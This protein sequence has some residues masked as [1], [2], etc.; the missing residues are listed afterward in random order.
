MAQWTHRALALLASLSVIAQ[1]SFTTAQLP[2]TDASALTATIDT[3]DAPGA[4]TLAL[5][6][7]SASLEMWLPP[8]WAQRL[9][10]P[11]RLAPPPAMLGPSAAESVAQN[12]RLGVNF[13][14][15]PKS[16]VGTTYP[17][18]RNAGASYNRTIFN[19][20]MLKPSPTAW[21]PAL[22]DHELSIAAAN[23]VRVLGVLGHPPNEGWACDR[24]ANP[25]AGEWWCVPRGLFLPWNDSGNVWA[26][27]VYQTVSYFKDRVNEWEVW[28]EPNLTEF[29][30]GSAAE[31]AQLVRVSYQAI[32]AADPSATVVLGGILRGVNIGRTDAIFAAIA[33]LP[34]A[35]ANHYY[36]DVL[37]YHSYDDGVCSTFDTIEHL[38]QV[39]WQPRVGNKPLWITEVG[40]A[41]TNTVITHPLGYALPEEQASFVIQSYAYSLHKRAQRHY[42]FRIVH[43][44]AQSDDW[45]LI[46]ADG[47]YRP[48]YTAYQVAARYLPSQFEWSVRQWANNAVSRITFYNTPLGRVS[49]LWNITNTTRTFAWSAIL[50]QAVVVQQ[51]GVTSTVNASGGL[52]TF[53]LPPAPHFRHLHPEGI[54]K[55]ASPPLIVI[56]PDTVPPTATLATLPPITSATRLT[57]TW[58]ASDGA[59]G[60]G[61]W[62]YELER[63][64]ND[65][66]WTRLGGNLTRTSYA[67]SVL[68]G[69]SYAFRVRARDRAGNLQPLDMTN[70][71]STLILT[72]PSSIQPR[73]F[74]PLALGP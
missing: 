53:T 46:A 66:N 68:P 20:F 8:N 69:N 54:C 24:P 49:V 67:V 18:A 33:A 21:T 11:D 9:R 56:E 65:G 43:D 13:A 64:V 36:F 32:K 58:T 16:G 26:Q 2:P 1:P 27:F 5:F 22:Y 14:I 71:V 50:P 59:G 7:P 15:Y 29:W 55:V 10:M 52:L 51:N 28:N 6:P 60:S 17:D 48:A 31:F 37:G 45:G 72:D 73:V 19:M 74:V 70:V 42:Y 40:I 23:N 34:D 4:H 44:P 63:R 41:V 35:A 3:D 39:Y 57:L 38:K 47:T 62:W 61:I 12:P 25:S 30:S